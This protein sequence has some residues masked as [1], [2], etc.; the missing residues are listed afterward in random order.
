MPPATGR[1]AVPH[2][3]ANNTRLPFTFSPRSCLVKHTD[4]LPGQFFLPF[5]NANDYRFSLY[6]T[7]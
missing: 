4:Q 3:I 7:A 1:E 5:A 6:F 2:K